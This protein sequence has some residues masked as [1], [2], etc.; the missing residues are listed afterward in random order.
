MIWLWLGAAWAADADV[1][2]EGALDLAAAAFIPDS[3]PILT[4]AGWAAE[5]DLW[6]VPDGFQLAVELDLGG[7]TGPIFPETL[8]WLTPERLSVR[9]GMGEV[10]FEGGVLP[11]PWGVESVDPWRNALASWS[12]LRRPGAGAIQ[13]AFGPDGLVPLGA[14][15]GG[16]FGAGSRD[17]GIMGMAGLDLPGGMNLLSDP[18]ED[19]RGASLIVGGHGFFLDRK[20]TFSGGAWA[21]PFDDG[22]LTIDAGVQFRP[23][24]W[25][26]TAE[27]AV[28]LNGAYGLLLQG[29]LAPGGVVSPVLRL[30]STS[31]EG[32]GA[33][34]G[35]CSTPWEVAR[36]KAEVRYA[37]QTPSLWAEAALF[38]KGAGRRTWR[39]GW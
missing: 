32:W 14:T 12:A 1:T 7:S 2:V 31:Y 6:V 36:L 4:G 30:E 20:T 34:L 11:P 27:G 39:P 16:G 17:R 38:S 10:W 3:G 33:A 23:T 21:H 5:G 19:V 26:L 35:V 18:L 29:E 25:W 22:P 24:G 8:T 13:G 9:V 28:A 37:A 15:I